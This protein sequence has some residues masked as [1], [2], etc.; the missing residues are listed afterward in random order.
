M[1]KK[2]ASK[3]PNISDDER[4]LQLWLHGVSQNTVKAYRR[5]M[6]AFRSW[7]GKP[8]VEVTLDDLQ[9]W[10]SSLAGADATRRR[11]LA[12]VKSGLAFGT[13]V[14]L[15]PVDVGAALRLE[16]ERDT[17]NERILLE[18]D[19]LRMIDS[20]QNPR[21]RACLRVLYLLGL[22]ISEMCALTWR[23]MTRRQ[24][25]GIASVFGKG[26]KTRSVPVP[27]KLWK[28]LMALRA[29]NRPDAP[30]VPG[31]DGG[32]L[33]LSA[34]HRLVK[35]AAG[36]AGLPDSVSA[37]WL[38]HA[39]ASHALDNGAPAHVVQATLGHA[40]LATTTRY[41]HVREGDGTGNYLKG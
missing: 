7:V 17:L 1:A 34:A 21:K 25:G 14:R 18:E 35:R 3:S 32:K 31:H 24:Q 10:Y 23:N 12:S 5:D 15:L 2:I 22:R 6:E 11:K 38:R 26:G 33:S 36:R 19:V 41:S 28:E 29:D 39:N 27:A 40:S 9:N 4:L 37:H 13:R 8:L 30:V 20:E 16:R